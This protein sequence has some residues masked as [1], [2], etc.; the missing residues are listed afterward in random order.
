[1]I[2]GDLARS[3]DLQILKTMIALGYC[4]ERDC[5]STLKDEVSLNRISR[6]ALN[7]V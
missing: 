5:R 3:A 7:L 4:I 1:M 6:T 2:T